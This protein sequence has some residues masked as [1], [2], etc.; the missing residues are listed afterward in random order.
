MTESLKIEY[1]NIINLI[2]CYGT[3]A[4][5]KQIKIDVI[6]SNESNERYELINVE[7]RGLLWKT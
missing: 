2:E 6:V 3:G 5:L 1:Q 7:G 4:D